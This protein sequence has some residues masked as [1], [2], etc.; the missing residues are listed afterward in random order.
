MQVLVHAK[1]DLDT[2]RTENGATPAFM[3][4]RQGH[5][6]LLQVLMHAEADIDKAMI[7]EGATPVSGQMLT[8]TGVKTEG[9]RLSAQQSIEAAHV[10]SNCGSGP[11]RA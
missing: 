4:G 7:Y 3:A 2:A 8:T 11:A 9:T 5:T 1:A 6:D 10:S